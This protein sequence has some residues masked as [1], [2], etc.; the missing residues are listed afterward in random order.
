MRK[1]GL[2][3]CLFFF[4]LCTALA[5]EAWPSEQDGVSQWII[6]LE[7]ENPGVRRAA[8]RALGTMKDLRAVEPLIAVLR[9]RDG[10]VRLYA[11]DALEKITGKDFGGDVKK[12][13]QWLAEGKPLPEG[14][15]TEEDEI[16][17]WIVALKSED[18][19][20][21]WAAT[22]ILGEMGNS[23]A[24]EPL[25]TALK[26]RDGVVRW[27]AA[28]ALSA[29]KDPK[30]VE[31]LIAALRDENRGVRG[32]A[33]WALA[34]IKDPRAVEP[35]IHALEDEDASVRRAAA[36]ILGELKDPKAVEPLIAALKDE[37]KYV[38]GAAQGALKKI[39]GKDFG[40]DVE[41][42]QQW[43]KKE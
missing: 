12:W 36:W 35:L 16:A 15:P 39:T 13:Q 30:A 25:I 11:A 9:D 17:R 1:R 3:L 5:L 26:D 7:D 20:V 23:R 21:R 41:R 29:I 24:V 27:T 42:W 8:A 4:L 33:A 6:A 34:E 14:R 22:R 2:L 18:K 31:P 28:V 38:R 43:L 19:F 10:G 32:D 37:D 40:E